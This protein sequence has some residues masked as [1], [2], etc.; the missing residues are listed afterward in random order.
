MLA[1]SYSGGG[2]IERGRSNPDT[3]ADVC[4]ELEVWGILWTIEV[5]AGLELEEFD[6]DETDGVYTAE[7]RSISKQESEAKFSYNEMYSSY[8]CSS[9]FH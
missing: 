7:N 3:I 8:K 5:R 4:K 2:Y 1:P 6:S 9:G